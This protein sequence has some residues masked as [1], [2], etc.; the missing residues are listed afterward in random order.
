MAELTE[1]DNENCYKVEI[2]LF[3]KAEV[4]ETDKSKFYKLAEDVRL[5]DVEDVFVMD[6]DGGLVIRCYDGADPHE[7]TIWD[8]CTASGSRVAMFSAPRGD[9]VIKAEDFNK[10]ISLLPEDATQKLPPI[11]NLYA[12][13][14]YWFI[15]NSTTAYIIGASVLV[16]LV[17]G[18]IIGVRRKKKNIKKAD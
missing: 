12:N 1:T 13:F 18:I 10:L 9:Y 8:N 5:V 4:Y 7:I 3:G 11:K 2:G 6:T 16:V 15:F 14:L 17:G